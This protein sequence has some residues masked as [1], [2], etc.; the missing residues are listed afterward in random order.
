MIV[1][2]ILWALLACCI[3]GSAPAQAD[4]GYRLWLRYTPV[5]GAA[6]TTLS[7]Q[8]TMLVAARAPSPTIAAALAEFDRGFTGLLGAPLPRTDTPRAGAI[9]IGTPATVPAIAALHLPLGSLGKEGYLIRS[10]H[11]A[12]GGATVIAANSDIGVLYGSFALLERIQRHAPLTGLDVSTA[13]RIKL[14]LLDHWDSLDGSIERGYAG[15]S[16]W[17]WWTLPDYKNPRYTDYAR[18]NASIGI[19]GAV[20]NNVNA[21]P[22]ILTHRYIV[23]AA[24]LADI[25]RPYGIKVYL[26]VNF[27]SPI[28]LGSL[29]TADPLDPQV[30]AWWKA[31]TDEI[32]RTIPDFGGFLV[33]AN[34]EGQPGPG[35]YH[36]THAQGAN[37]LAAVL[38]P[39]SGI[40]MWRA[41]VYGASTDQDRAKQAYDQFKPLDGKFASN[42]IVQVKNGPIDFQ[43]REPFSPLFGAMPKTPL[44]MEFQ[45]TKEYLGQA[46]HLVY[47]GPLFEE[48]L[49]SDTYAK[50]K[51]STVARDIDGSLNGNTL[52]GIAGVAN[53][54]RDRDWS[55]STFNQANWF[56]FGR[57]AWNPDASARDIAGEWSQL[58]FGPDPRITQPV[59]GMM[60]LSRE[61]VVNYMTPLGLAHQMAT[62][63]HYGPGPWVHDLAQPDWNPVYYNRADKS[64]IGFD[65]TATGSDAV[66]QY[67]PPVAAT[68][69]SLATCPDADLLWF[70]HL[71]WNYR[72]RSG[73]TLWQSLTAHYQ[74]GVEQVA[75]MARSWASLKPLVDPQRFAKT[76]DLLSIQAREATWWRDASVLYWSSVSGLKPPPSYP[77]PA[78]DLSY[79]EAL[80]FDDAP[81][82]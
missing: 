4:D 49:Q 25:F 26:S 82:Q 75:G 58:T 40:V 74:L 65:R 2:R 48:T 18:A 16:L 79:Y 64:G 68:F 8:A 45:I 37:M 71:P 17:D 6:R 62:G 57:M 38:A 1:R 55:G 76:T 66:A 63:S 60:M 35:D 77:A 22:Q 31:K 59:V 69:S 52:T 7:A 24:A 72:M 47:L 30:A 20:L 11:L 81:G 10:V 21:T 23:K 36:R 13:P 80:H 53:I 34:S 43:P 9:L 70:H 51:G 50:G 5:S 67:Y 27:A 32:Y 28:K 14:R 78:H 19:N 56:V 12:G 61:A 46:T 15:Q 29:H 73:E 33:K 54:G 42:V 39:H 44:M 3:M 41:F